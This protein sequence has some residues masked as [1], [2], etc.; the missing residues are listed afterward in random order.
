MYV[1]RTKSR[2]L[3]EGVRR[4]HLKHLRVDNQVAR[5][6]V[7]FAARK[8]TDLAQLK[9]LIKQILDEQNARGARVTVASL[10]KTG[11]DKFGNSTAPILA[12]S[13]SV[14]Y[15]IDEVIQTRH[16]K[17]HKGKKR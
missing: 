10:L 8:A 5:A 7:V 4:G 9:E 17:K 15:E 6:I 2:A 3:C 11:I 13:S 1:S 14:Q 12:G 16:R